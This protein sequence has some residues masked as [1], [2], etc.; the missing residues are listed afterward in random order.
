M[1]S[2]DED[3]DVD[4][5]SQPPAKARKRQHRDELA[6]VGSNETHLLCFHFRAADHKVHPNLYHLFYLGVSDDTSKEPVRNELYGWSPWEEFPLGNSQ[7]NQFLAALEF[8]NSKQVKYSKEASEG[9][10]DI[11][12]T[13]ISLKRFDCAGWTSGVDPEISIRQHFC[14]RS[15]KDAAMICSPQVS[16]KR[17]SLKCERCEVSFSSSRQIHDHVRQCYV[18]PLCDAPERLLRLWPEAKNLAVS[19]QSGVFASKLKQT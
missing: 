1:S 18:I 6:R 13:S 4:P 17:L 12:Q 8:T 10:F 2:D 7:A 3:S 9:Q 16:R 19:A 5:F 14:P 15:P 11:L